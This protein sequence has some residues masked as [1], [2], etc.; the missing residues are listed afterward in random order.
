MAADKGRHFFVGF[1][2]DDMID[3]QLGKEGFYDRQDRIYCP[4]LI[5]TNL[6]QCEAT[7]LISY[8][9]PLK[10][11]KKAW[12][13]FQACSISFILYKATHSPPNLMYW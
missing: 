1:L 5:R 7:H 13:F 3:F 9:A 8:I 4:F 12:N 6:T 2:E 11:K 10:S